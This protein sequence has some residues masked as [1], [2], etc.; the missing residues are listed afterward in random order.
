MKLNQILD[1]CKANIA[2]DQPL[3][4]Q[5]LES[6]FAKSVVEIFNVVTSELIHGNTYH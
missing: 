3:I 4:Q 1:F 6:F 5:T 2:I